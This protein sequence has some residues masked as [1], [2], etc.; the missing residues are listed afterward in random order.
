MSNVT[1]PKLRAKKD[2][3]EKN[4]K[5]EAAKKKLENDKHKEITTKRKEQ[6][7]KDKAEANKKKEVGGILWDQYWKVSVTTQRNQYGV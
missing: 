6:E 2:A 1:T 4:V 7:S 5:D 3:F